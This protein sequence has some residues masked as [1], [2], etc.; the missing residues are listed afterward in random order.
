MCCA[1][2]LCAN[3]AL[4]S[5][6]CKAKEFYKRWKRPKDSDTKEMLRKDFSKGMESVGRCVLGLLHILCY[7]CPHIRTYSRYVCMKLS[8]AV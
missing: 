2:V 1:C 5:H 8:R 7:T 6:F 4:I 3:V